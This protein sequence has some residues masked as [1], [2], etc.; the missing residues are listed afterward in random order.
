MADF[1]NKLPKVAVARTLERANWANTTLVK[2][3]V[4]EKIKEIK[5]Q[6]D[7]NIFVFGSGR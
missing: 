5:L 3:N 7:G 4:V 1:M 6:G 2:E